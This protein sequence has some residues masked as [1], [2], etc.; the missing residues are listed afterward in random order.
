[1]T[2]VKNAIMAKL[3]IALGLLVAHNLKCALNEKLSDEMLNR[4]MERMVKMYEGGMQ[5]IKRQGLTRLQKWVLFGNKKKAICKR[6]L[7]VNFRLMAAGFNKL[8]SDNNARKEAMETK[9]RFIIK[10]LR[11]QDSRDMG[12]AYNAMKRQ[13]NLLLGVGLGEAE[14]LKKRILRRLMDKGYDWLFTS[15]DT[16]QRVVKFLKEKDEADNKAKERFLKR[17]MNSS[18]REIG[19]ALRMLRANKDEEEKLERERAFKHRG[20]CNRMLDVNTR[21]MSAGYN[22]LLEEHKAKMTMLREKLK[23]VLQTLG[24]KDLKFK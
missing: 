11:D 23:F 16:L 17:F 22:K 7:D 3:K 19:C 8:I 4:L 6:I 14:K 5:G 24:D 10:S 21:L 20:V 13:C 18:L 9:L 12:L 1:M 15:F 2:K